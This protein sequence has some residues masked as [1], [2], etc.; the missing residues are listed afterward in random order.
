M[1]GLATPASLINYFRESAGKFFGVPFLDSYRFFFVYSFHLKA[2]YY[3]FDFLKSDGFKF[4]FCFQQ[5]KTG[6]QERRK[7]WG[8]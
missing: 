7:K 4:D 2:S 6:N 3:Q 5:D 8:L 1:W